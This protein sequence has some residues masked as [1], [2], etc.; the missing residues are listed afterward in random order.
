ML[1]GS[2]D[3]DKTDR[4]QAILDDFMAARRNG[5][6]PS[7]GSYIQ[8]NP[9]LEEEIRELLP[10]VSIVEGSGNRAPSP[11]APTAIQKMLESFNGYRVIREIGRGGMGIVYEVEQ[12]SPRRRVAM[13]VLR[14]PIDASSRERFLRESNVA[15]KIQ[16]PNITPVYEVGTAD[17]GGTPLI[18][19]TM[20]LID[21]LTLERLRVEISAVRSAPDDVESRSEIA[22]SLIRGNRLPGG[23]SSSQRLDFDQPKNRRFGND[24]YFHNLAVILFHATDAV[25]AAHGNGFLH[26]D[27]KPSNILVDRNL[28]V[29][30]TDFGLAKIADHDLTKTG[31]VVGSVRYMAPE[32]FRGQCDERADVYALGITL[33]ELL[34]LQ[35]PFAW[36]EPMQI[37][38]QVLE[39]EPISPRLID[40]RIPIDLETI[41]LKACD[42]DPQRRY[43]SCAEMASDL[44]RYINDQPI[45]ARRLS[46]IQKTM[47][48]AMRN[49]TLAASLA[50]ALTA[51]LIAI[52]GLAVLAAARESARQTEADMRVRETTARKRSEAMAK[53]HQQ[54]LYFSE[55]NL[56]L[57]AMQSSGGIAETRKILQRWDPSRHPHLNIDWCWDF[58]SA[59]AESEAKVWRW[60]TSVNAHAWNHS[61]DEPL[62]AIAAADGLEIHA[63]LESEP[64]LKMPWPGIATSLTWIDQQNLVVGDERGEIVLLKTDS[65][66]LDLVCTLNGAINSLALNADGTHLAVSTGAKVFQVDLSSSACT[67]MASIQYNAFRWQPMA[68]SPQG[69]RLAILGAPDSLSLMVL[70]LATKSEAIQRKTM[71]A[72][73]SVLWSGDGGEIIVGS[74]NGNVSTYDAE[75][76]EE[77]HQWSPHRHYIQSLSRI[78]GTN[79][80]ASGGS[81]RAVQIW[82]FQ[83]RVI[84]GRLIGAEDYIRQIR[85]STDG[86]W[87]SACCEDNALRMWRTPTARQTNS[88][89][90]GTWE[91]CAHAI[92]IHPAG[93]LIC[94]VQE[95][96]QI[97]GFERMTASPNDSTQR[98]SFLRIRD[99]KLE[100]G[101]W[102]TAMAWDP[103]GEHL[104]CCREGRLCWTSPR[105]SPS[106]T[107]VVELDLNARAM[108]WSPAGKHLALAGSSFC[109]WDFAQQTP[110]YWDED[111]PNVKAVEYSQDG[112]W[113]VTGCRDSVRLYQANPPRFVNNFPTP[114]VTTRISSAP[115]GKRIAV[116]SGSGIVSIIE[117]PS[118]KQL[119]TLQGHTQDVFSVDWHP[120][121]N[122]LATGSSD[123]TVRIWD[124]NS[125][126]QILAFPPESTPILS[127]EWSRDG[128]TLASVA[129]GANITIRTATNN[130]AP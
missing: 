115:D 89:H 103:T 33:Y 27:L 47:R 64:R 23:E 70:D 48:W 68:W 81:D 57:Q 21:G 40:D 51:C 83:T 35:R 56:A 85:S 20:Q 65:Q 19:Y 18:Y 130:R 24:R 113:I 93:Q 16:H 77:I 109:V 46:A 49:K 126:R 107:N 90:L 41:V 13:K 31:E 99:F 39:R 86:N 82:D 55:M 30:V 112:Q 95:H 72:G 111:S 17:D 80:I 15:A 71:V 87:I 96:N 54:D 26:R 11:L 36:P 114:G 3:E 75:S 92:A 34:T 59:E 128:K 44:H 119:G 98:S 127:V 62:V 10:L 106:A 124:V 117:I 67:E 58:L 105:S 76:L 12:A 43:P 66:D 110:L 97:V 125:T 52:G 6:T 123:G 118:G 63:P 129:A 73:H 7:I 14:G 79:L 100:L 69:D 42:K 84:A 94:A 102:V 45:E 4:L 91:N 2:A 1:D 37:I 9:D 38:K 50:C 53:N 22:Q 61:P 78:P 116:A 25:Q 5:E 120:N 74:E 32:R 29:W 88:M 101:A 60:A 28:K 122:H 104:A 108:S 121:G 8:A